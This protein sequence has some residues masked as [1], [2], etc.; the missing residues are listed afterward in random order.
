LQGIS[1]ATWKIVSAFYNAGWDSLVTDIHN[2]ILRQ[3]I[4]L[5]YT[6]KTNLVKNSKPKG[7]D[8]NKLASIE[9][10]PPPILTKTP[11]EINKISE[12]FKTKMSTHAN[13]SQDKSYA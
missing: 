6:P 1:K 8:I 5:Y 9:R 11:K 2:N 7:K 13:I 10:L 12:F 3:K 4:S